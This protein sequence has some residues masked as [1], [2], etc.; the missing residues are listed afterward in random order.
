MAGAKNLR[1]MKLLTAV[2]LTSKSSVARAQGE[3]TQ[4][5]FLQMPAGDRARGFNPE[6][7]L[8]PR[9]SWRHG[10]GLQFSP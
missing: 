5:G 8:L 4:R 3:P 10:S 9:V 7:L 6:P 2:Y 1:K